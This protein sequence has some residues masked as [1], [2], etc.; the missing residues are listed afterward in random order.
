MKDLTTLA[1]KKH[2]SKFM[3]PKLSTNTGLS[4][5]E[6]FRHVFLEEHNAETNISIQKL[7]L[8]DGVT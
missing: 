1:S 8:A 6:K 2:E 7:D 5:S 3:W 4:G